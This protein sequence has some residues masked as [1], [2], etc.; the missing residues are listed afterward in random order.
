MIHF[1]FMEDPDVPWALALLDEPDLTFRP[2]ETTY[3]I[4]REIVSSGRLL[5][6]IRFVRNF[7][8]C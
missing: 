2:D 7:S 1:G 4:G 3:F 5:V 6:C 8:S